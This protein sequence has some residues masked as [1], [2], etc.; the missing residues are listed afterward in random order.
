M[1]S[2]AEARYVADGIPG[3]KLVMV[4]GKDYLPWVGDQETLIS[5]LTAFA[6]GTRR[7]AEPHRVLLTVLFTDIVD[8][9]GW[10]AKVGDERWRELLA[11]HDRIVHDALRRFRGTEVDRTGDGVFAIFEGPGRRFSARRRSEAR[12]DG[13]A[14]RSAPGSTP[15]RSTSTASA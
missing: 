13:T 4:P 7:P 15:A 11:E 10:L 6:T 1:D 8:S 9:T 5:E 2:L 14:S 12:R 3:S